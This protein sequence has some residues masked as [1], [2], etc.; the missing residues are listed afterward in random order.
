MSKD[1]VIIDLVAVLK[2]QLEARRRRQVQADK[3]GYDKPVTFESLSK[4]TFPT[5]NGKKRYL[6]SDE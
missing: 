3:L 2:S 4:W 1:T 6:T 5:R